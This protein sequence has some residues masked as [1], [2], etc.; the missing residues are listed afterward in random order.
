MASR[1]NDQWRLRFVW[2]DGEPYEVELVDY[3]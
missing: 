2:R 3:H 1:C